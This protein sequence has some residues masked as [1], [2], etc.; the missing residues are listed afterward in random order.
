MVP[1]RN[2]DGIHKA[3]KVWEEDEEEQ[4]READL[5]GESG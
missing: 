4:E 5:V 2:G 3:A 1:T